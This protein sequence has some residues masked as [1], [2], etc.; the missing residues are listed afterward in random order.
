MIPPIAIQQL[1]TILDNHEIAIIDASKY[2]QEEL[3]TIL[4]N[5]NIIQ[6]TAQ[7]RLSRSFDLSDLDNIHSQI[8]ECYYVRIDGRRRDY[9]LNEIS[10]LLS[11]N[12][13]KMKVI[14]HTGYG[15]SYHVTFGQDIEAYL[16][17]PMDCQESLDALTEKM[18]Q[19]GLNPRSV[20]LDLVVDALEL[21]D[22]S[23][24]NAKKEDFLLAL[25]EE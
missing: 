13:S 2:S 24:R 25:S 15:T 23:I 18:R 16:I 19:F 1:K 21:K 12:R 5:Y 4:G 22:L 7:L 17:T 3:Y 9:S 6:D 10:E 8:K 20:D 14:D 11:F